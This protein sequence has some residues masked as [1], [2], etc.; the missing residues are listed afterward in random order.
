LKAWVWFPP[1]YSTSHRQRPL[2]GV[3]YTAADSHQHR[4][5]LRMRRTTGAAPV[6]AEASAVQVSPDELQAAVLLF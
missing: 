2:S 1:W 6:A 5:Q 4:C 3:R